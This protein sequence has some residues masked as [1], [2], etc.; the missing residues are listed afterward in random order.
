MKELSITVVL[1]LG[2]VT[3]R[4]YLRGKDWTNLYIYIYILIIYLFY[5]A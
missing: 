2:V 5:Y 4:D 3:P 1:N